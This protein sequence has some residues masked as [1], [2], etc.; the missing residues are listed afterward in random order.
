MLITAKLVNDKEVFVNCEDKKACAL[1]DN[2]ETAI[3]FIAYLLGVTIDLST[4]KAAECK[5][6][7]AERTLAGVAPTTEQSKPYTIQQVHALMHGGGP[8]PYC[9]ALSQV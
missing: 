2:S 9:G 3:V 8:C 4:A 5:P 6:E 7:T 1:C